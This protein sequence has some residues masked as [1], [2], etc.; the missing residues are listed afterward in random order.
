MEK[1]KNTDRE[2]IIGNR[3][4][5]EDAR[6]F[7]SREDVLRSFPEIQSYLEVGVLAG[8]YSDMV[9]KRLSPKTISLLDLFNCHDETQHNRFSPS[10]HLNFIENKYSKSNA[11]IE[12]IAGDSHKKMLEM[13]VGGKRYDYIYIDANHQTSGA[14][15]D[16]LLASKLLSDNG[17]IG[18]NDFVVY[19]W[20]LQKDCGVI[21]AV[22]HF[23]RHFEEWEIFAYSM[24]PGEGYYGDVYLRKKLSQRS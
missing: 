4:I 14:Y 17:I 19:F 7:L 22:S 2:N 11:N 16:L 9:I 12:I 18:L 20:S 23:L 10:S 13:I 21:D 1:E 24:N 5:A 3:S 15:G 6:L 8:D